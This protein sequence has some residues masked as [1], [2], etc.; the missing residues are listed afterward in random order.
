MDDIEAIKQL[1]ARYF[2]LMDTKD[3]D[4]FRQV[5]ADDVIMDSTGSGGTAI[6]GG[7]AFLAYISANLAEVVTVHQG[8]T[9]EITLT[10]A[11]T[12]NGVWALADR[13]WWPDGRELSGFGHYYETYEK[14]DGRWLIKSSRLTRLHMDLTKPS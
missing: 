2:R 11:T 12:A 1:K 10:S 13:L 8:H 14:T 5:F 3:W 6:T 9:P 4:G 7:D